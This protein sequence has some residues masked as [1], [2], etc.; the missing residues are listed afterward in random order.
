MCL[1]INR[2]RRCDVYTLRIDLN[3]ESFSSR[4]FY[5][6]VWRVIKSIKTIN[7]GIN[8][9]IS[10]K[11]NTPLLYAKHLAKHICHTLSYPWDYL[12]GTIYV[13]CLIY[14]HL[15]MYQEFEQLYNLQTQNQKRLITNHK[16]SMAFMAILS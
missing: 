2:I 3:Y 10:K 4:L 1:D 14:K 5:F 15:S 12:T 7:T 9:C 11:G 13:I 8:L 16:H 6:L